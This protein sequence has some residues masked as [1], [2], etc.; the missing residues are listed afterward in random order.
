M[1]FETQCIQC[2][3]TAHRVVDAAQRMSSRGAYRIVGVATDVSVVALWYDIPKY[4]PSV[5]RSMDGDSR[6]HALASLSLLG[7]MWVPDQH[8]RDLPSYWGL[9]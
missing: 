4:R 9:I 7:P 3:R 6:Q 5:P 1:F 2:T 8:Y